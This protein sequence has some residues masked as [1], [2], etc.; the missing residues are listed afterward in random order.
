MV[1]DVIA[2]YRITSKIGEGGMGAVYRA[3]DTKLGRDVAIKIIPEVFIQDADRMARFTREAHLLA[4]LNHPNIAT[5]HGIEPG[6]IVMELVEG[7]TLA[8]MIEG[9]AGP[10]PPIP[11]SDALL[12]ARQ[13]A[14]ALEYAHEHAVVHRDLKPANVKVTPEGQVKVLDFGL[15]KAMADDASA[16]GLANSPTLTARATRAGVILGTAAYM[17]PEQ[18]I[19]K[20]VDRRA[21]IWAFGAVLYEMLTGSRGFGGDS[22]VETLAAVMKEEPDWTRLPAETPPSV[23]R[24]LRRCLDKDPKRRLRDIGEARIALD[25]RDRGETDVAAPVSLAAG[26]RR[27]VPVAWI[28]AGALGAALLAVTATMFVRA[29]PADPPV[30]RSSILPPDQAAFNF[31]DDTQLGPMALSPDGRLVTFSAR[32]PDAKIRLWVRPLDS[33]SAREL[34]G[35]DGG[36][37]P[38]WS[39]DSQ[40]IGFFA[41]RKLKRIPAAGGISTPLADVTN[42]RG[43]TWSADDV[44]LFTP[45]YF[46]PI[47]KV[48]AN[49][50][51]TTP[52]STLDQTRS[53]TSNRFPWFLPDGRHFL[54]TAQDT[55]VVDEGSTIRLASL[56]SKDSRVLMESDSNVVY[57][58]GYLLYL[59]AKSSTLVAQPF[60]AKTLTVTGEPL[61]LVEN[62]RSVRFTSCG[63]FSVSTNGLL[64]HQS[65]AADVDRR[66]T[67]VDRAGKPIRTAGDPIRST[68]GS[69]H[70][71]L[72]Q[73][74]LSLSLQSGTTKG[75]E[76]W[77]QDMTR[78]VRT[79]LTSS[80]RVK[81]AAVWSPDGQMVVFDGRRDGQVGPQNLYRSLSNGGRPEELLYADDTNKNP[82]SWSPDG[83]LLLYTAGGGAA[84]TD[85][86]VLPD[87]LGPPGPRKPFGFLTSRFSESS[88]QFSPDGRSVAYSSNEPERAEIWVTPFPGPGKKL[89]I[90]TAG[91]ISPRWRFDG[92][93]IFYV[94]P[95]GRLMAAEM[96]GT[97]NTMDVVKVQP[98]FS[99]VWIGAGTYT[100]DVA[101][102][103]QSFLVAS[104]R[105]SSSPTEPL[106]LVQN[107][108]AGLARK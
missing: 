42:G 5:I 20:T 102:D 92:R 24:L 67:W 27:R 17:S 11:L 47:L 33:A 55:N 107:W 58:Q 76:I 57:S 14:E 105:G 38:F 77:I 15:A 103:G 39:P 106:T 52:V 48:S 45:S 59:R 63:V 7:Q 34:S 81:R 19:G 96:E 85:V 21:D 73:K 82:T 94:A 62:V 18:A 12:I 6:A 41:D 60:D 61:T 46:S 29:K 49:G 10:G 54:Y 35:T 37:Y 84:G 40:H 13:I 88:A 23:R 44:I 1:P 98:L 53:E 25:D 28:T 72:D 89:R 50:G 66:L 31:S 70:L 93:E 78:N 100:Y 99:G 36:T 87:P 56:D 64:I 22:L 68:V 4:S 8:E 43:G 108:T 71:S 74:Q 16:V 104:S 75:S 3:T 79:P 90:S 2:H 69:F 30:L 32:G 9:A 51:A 91:G 86:L 95:G 101:R 80:A 65:G 26:P 83:K 97:G